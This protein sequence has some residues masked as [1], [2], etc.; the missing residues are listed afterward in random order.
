M[1][2]PHL[3]ANQH[4]LAEVLPPRMTRLARVRPWGRYKSVG[5]AVIVQ[6]SA[7][8]EDHTPSPVGQRTRPLASLPDFLLMWSF[9]RR[10]SN[11]RTG[12]EPYANQGV[13]R[14]VNS[15]EGTGSCPFVISFSRLARQPGLPPVATTSAN[16]VWAAQPLAQA[17]PQL[18]AGRWRRVPRSVR[19]ATSPIASST[20]ANANLSL[21]TALSAIGVGRA[22]D[23]S[24]TTFTGTAQPRLTRHFALPVTVKGTADV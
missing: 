21:R 6:C 10:A 14:L 23:P 3:F 20:P 13:G 15:S 17:Q 22:S 2:S 7:K 18:P 19:Q 8:H 9:W 16:K 24:N 4:S 12:W 11:R 1:L 5:G